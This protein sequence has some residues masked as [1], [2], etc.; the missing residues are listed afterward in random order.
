MRRTSKTRR[1]RMSF[2]LLAA[3]VSMFSV[4]PVRA[5]TITYFASLSPEVPGA[6]GTGSAQVVID[7]TAHSLLVDTTWSGLSAG[8]TVAH[9][10]CCTLTPGTGTVGVAVTPGTLPGFPTG[11]TSGQYTSPLIDLTQ[12][13]SYTGGAT[14]FLTIFGGGTVAG[15]E[16]ALLA[17]LN[18]GTAYFNIHSTAFPSG[19][20]RGFLAVPGPIAGVG[21]PGLILA[22]GGLLGW[23]RRRRAAA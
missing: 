2:L 9:I 20:I 11:Q 16:A 3:A 6:T 15:A 1:S 13:S 8:T 19:E 18:G 21:L 5:D 4:S 23:W 14:G 7:T 10:H 22:S 12:A 17:G